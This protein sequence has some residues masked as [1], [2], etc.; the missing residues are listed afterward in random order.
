MNQLNYSLGES[1]V[2]PRLVAAMMKPVGVVDLIK[3][4]KR[5]IVPQLMDP[6]FFGPNL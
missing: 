5:F 2:V 3:C 4:L 1:E 6:V